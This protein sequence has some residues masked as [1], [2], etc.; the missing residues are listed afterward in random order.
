M[1]LEPKPMC[2]TITHVE[3]L[4][5]HKVCGPYVATFLNW[6]PTFEWYMAWPIIKNTKNTFVTLRLDCMLTIYQPF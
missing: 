1:N 3:G 4:Q 6:T 2:T 5:V